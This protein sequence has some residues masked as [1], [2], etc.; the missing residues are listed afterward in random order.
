MFEIYDC[1]LYDYFEKFIQ[2]LTLFL[3]FSFFLMF[4]YAY[5]ISLQKAAPSFAINIYHT[6]FIF[7]LPVEQTFTGRF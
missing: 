4:I 5:F 3:F 6:V 2:T 7:K 1:F